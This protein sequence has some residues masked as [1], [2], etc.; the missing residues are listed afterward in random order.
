MQERLEE[1]QAELRAALGRRIAKAKADYKV[2]CEHHRVLSAVVHPCKKFAHFYGCQVACI[3]SRQYSLDHGW[4]SR[5]ARRHVRSAGRKEAGHQQQSSSQRFV[6]KLRP[7]KT[8]S[9]TVVLSM[10]KFEVE[11]PLKLKVK[12]IG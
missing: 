10:G 1:C 7:Q 12:C 9:K 4:H 5:Q 8:S 11:R 6:G 2:S 3:C